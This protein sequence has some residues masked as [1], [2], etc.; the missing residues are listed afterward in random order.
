MLKRRHGFSLIELLIALAIAA[1][2]LMLG[3]PSI[4]AWLANLKVRSASEAF[5]DGMQLAR[6][7]AIKRNEPVQ[8]LLGTGTG[9]T[10]RLF[11]SGTNLQTRPNG[12]ESTGVI[13]TEVNGATSLIFDSFGRIWTPTAAS[14]W[15]VPASITQIDLKVDISFVPAAE[16][17]P[18]RILVST[19]GG[20]IRLCNPKVTDAGDPRKC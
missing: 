3:V 10:V 18:L 20:Q 6:N 1:L 13:A 19:P 7:E 12:E 17:N 5:L 2:V 4:K 15:V 11:S 8:F 14:A 9:W 16:Q